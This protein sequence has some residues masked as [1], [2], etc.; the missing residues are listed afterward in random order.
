MLFMY[1]HHFVRFEAAL[2]NALQLPQNG[3]NQGES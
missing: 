2:Q 3:T 1:S